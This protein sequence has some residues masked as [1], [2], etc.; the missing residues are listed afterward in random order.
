M[1]TPTTVNS[2]ETYNF[3]LQDYFEVVD[4]HLYPEFLSSSCL[5][6]QSMSTPIE[7]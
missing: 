7:S 4:T 5:T 6:L 1:Y 2:I 3:N